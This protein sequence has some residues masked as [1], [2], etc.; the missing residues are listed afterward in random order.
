[1]NKDNLDPEKSLC[2]TCKHGL[3]L[4]QEEHANLSHTGFPGNSGNNTPDYLP[5]N[6]FDEAQGGGEELERHEI[7][8]TKVCSI[9]HYI[10]PGRADI[11]PT[12][13]IAVIT[14]CNRYEEEIN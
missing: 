5:S 9:C 1:M 8:S 10:P 12:I 14:Q 2:W 3:C 13:N 7:R 6:V 11:P 4:K